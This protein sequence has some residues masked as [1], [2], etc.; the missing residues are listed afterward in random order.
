MTDVSGNCCS[1]LT[2]APQ[3]VICIA[4]NQA[5]RLVCLD[6]LSLQHVTDR[7]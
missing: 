4:G 1:M 5:Y 2:D 7:F 3:P 6:N